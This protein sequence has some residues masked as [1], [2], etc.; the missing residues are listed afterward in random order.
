MK[1]P[2][3]TEFIAAAKKGWEQREFDWTTFDNG[4]GACS[5]GA[6]AIGLGVPFQQLR[7]ALGKNL[8]VN[9]SWASVAKNKEQAVANIETLDWE[10]MHR[11]TQTTD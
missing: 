2:T 6:A 7:V 10:V 5:I 8:C 4:K 11:E 3:R 1:K 9:I